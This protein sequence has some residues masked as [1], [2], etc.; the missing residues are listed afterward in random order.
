MAGGAD[1]IAFFGRNASGKISKE[2]F[3]GKAANLAR[4]V[5]LAVPVPPGFA[6]GVSIC[7]DF[8]R[9][10]GQLPSDVPKLL[11]K[12]L[13]FVENATGLKYGDR[14]RPLL[15]SVRS[16]APVSMPGLM[17]TLLNVGLNRQ[18]LDGLV[19]MTGN[20]R[21]AWDS[22]RRLIQGMG[23]TVFLHEAG[24]YDSL[25]RHALH[26]EGVPDAIEL[27][28]GSLRRLAGEYEGLFADLAGHRFPTDV[29][30]QLRLA[31]SAVLGSARGARVEAFLKAQMLESAPSTAV[32]VQTMVFGNRGMNSGAGVAFTRDPSTGVDEMMVDFKF[33]AQGEDVV[34]GEATGSAAEFKQAM[35]E[36]FRELERVCHRLEQ[37]SKDMQ[38]VE[39]T[40][41]EGNLF[42][43][44]SRVGKRAP[45]AALR[46]AVE[47]VAEGLLT[48]AA[49][50]VQLG[51]LDPETIVV[52]RVASPEEPLG[53]GEPASAGV[54]SGR[55]A[56]TSERAEAYACEGPT[57][58]VRTTLS[59]DDLPG[60]TA[61]AGV[62]AA[63]GARTSHAAV[64]ARQLGKVCIVNCPNLALSVGEGTCRFGSRAV[65]EGEVITLDGN[66]GAVYA[67]KLGVV[68]E[69]PTELIET[70][71]RWRAG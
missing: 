19:F 4:M 48:P 37:D 23:Q 65:A 15:V 16:G 21:F 32:T 52:S 35:P 31:T 2:E 18:T 9:A 61:S 28:S 8:H 43:L 71:R 5:S 51:D 3:G 25:L 30:E 49:G 40:V 12:G 41:Q 70:V 7:D 54:A 60:V 14:R 34:S 10:G 66:V 17:E 33:G 29:G 62:L 6:L 57:I 64:V 45:L 26:S 63:R 69:K 38:D 39:F 24:P 13:Q 27:D 68:E 44:Q 11:E 58:L 53:L 56:L 55:V 1:R 59:P 36:M 47:M 46:I 42:I 22:Y 20:P 50:L 67:G